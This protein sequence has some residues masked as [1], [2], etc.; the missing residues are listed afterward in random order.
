LGV[1]RTWIALGSLAGLVA[2]AMAA[3]AGA[4]PARAEFL[5]LGDDAEQ[6][7]RAGMHSRPTARANLQRGDVLVR[8]DVAPIAGVNDLHR[9]LTAER[10]GMAIDAMML[11]RPELLTDRDK[12]SFSSIVAEHALCQGR[13]NPWIFLE[14]P[15]HQL[16]ADHGCDRIGTLSEG[17]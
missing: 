2:E 7:C 11:R 1:Q 14:V 10:A 15:A 5:W 17:P 9:A 3:L 6:R 13:Q 8:F 4:W 12:G 16:G